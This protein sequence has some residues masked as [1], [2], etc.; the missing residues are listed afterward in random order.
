M[1]GLTRRS[2]QLLRRVEALLPA[3]LAIGGGAGR[4]QALSVVVSGG[5]LHVAALADPTVVLSTYVPGAEAV[6]DVCSRV[7]EELTGV[8]LDVPEGDRTPRSA[9]RCSTPTTG[10][11]RCVPATSRCR[12]R[13]GTG[14]WPSA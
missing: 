2:A 5:Q 7:H 8:A 13:R 9:P 3:H 1:W 10:G 6:P 4:I 11:S 12:P 14:R